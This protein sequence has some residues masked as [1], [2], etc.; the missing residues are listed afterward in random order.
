MA[1]PQ[2]V[3]RP[4]ALVVDD[5]PVLLQLMARA[6]SSAYVVHTATNALQAL[7]IAGDLPNGPA[8]LVTDLRMD[9][10]NGADLAKLVAGKWPS[11]RVLF[12]SG[13]DNEHPDLAG[14]LLR[15]PFSPAQLV[16]AVSQVLSAPSQGH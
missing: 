15:K 12:V 3:S 2:S 6:L 16:E 8:I 14:P 10:V 11:T 1:A 5:E 7:E 13:F 9:P 4:S